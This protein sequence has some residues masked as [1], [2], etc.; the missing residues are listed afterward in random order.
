MAKSITSA[1]SVLTLTATTRGVQTGLSTS[2]GAYSSI[3]GIPV[4]LE[5]WAADN[6]FSTEAVESSIIVLGV[7]GKAHTGWVPYTVSFNISLMPDSDSQSFIDQLAM[8]ERTMRESLSLSSVLAIPS[9]EKKYY[10]TNGVL[11]RITPIASHG[12][13]QA[14]QQAT[15]VY[16]QLQMMPY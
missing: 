6:A 4:T 2:L 10:L 16:S 5:G 11:S 14:A 13:V 9:T 1:N 15:L 8:I 3:L 12:R 7:D